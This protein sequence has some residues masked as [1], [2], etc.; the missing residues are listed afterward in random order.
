MGNSTLHINQANENRHVVCLYGQRVA[1]IDRVDGKG[2]HQYRYK[3]VP[4]PGTK[5]L[6]QNKMTLNHIPSFDE[7]V[8]FVKHTLKDYLIASIF[9][10]G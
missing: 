1:T 9:L 4:V 5:K 6:F 2:I 7:A 10:K 8:A 3:V